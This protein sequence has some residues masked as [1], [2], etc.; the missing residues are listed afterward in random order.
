MH[1][2]YQISVIPGFS[3]YSLKLFNADSSLIFLIGRIPVMYAKARNFLDSS[4]FNMG[5]SKSSGMAYTDTI[6][7]G[8]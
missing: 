1:S 6:V 4:L 5:F 7:V 3:L 8:S 2:V